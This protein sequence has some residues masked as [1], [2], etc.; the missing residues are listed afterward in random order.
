MGGGDDNAFSADG[1]GPGSVISSDTR[2]AESDATLGAGLSGSCSSK[3][4]DCCAVICGSWL[5]LVVTLAE[6]VESALDLLA[7]EFVNCVDLADACT[8]TKL[9]PVAAAPAGPGGESGDGEGGAR[10]EG[11]VVEE[12]GEDGEVLELLDVEQITAAAE[13]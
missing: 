8:P 1:A 12:R 5:A 11:I 13:V 9:E 6:E 4:V 7:V 3:I 2:S 10:G